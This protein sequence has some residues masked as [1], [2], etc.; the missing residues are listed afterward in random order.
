MYVTRRAFTG[1]TVYIAERGHLYTLLRSAMTRTM[2][3]IPATSVSCARAGIVST[4]LRVFQKNSTPKARPTFSCQP[5]TTL[6]LVSPR[7]S[8]AL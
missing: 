2:H 3:P 6:P 1:V 4:P 7:F 5:R 8:I